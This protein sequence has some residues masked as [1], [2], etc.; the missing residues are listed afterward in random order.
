MESVFF[1]FPSDLALREKWTKEVKRTR[2][3]WSGPSEHSVLCEKHF[4][5]ECFEPA[6][7]IAATMGLHKRKRL[8]P[9]AV[10]TVFERR[11]QEPATAASLNEP[12]CSG[13]SRSRKR[14][15]ASVITPAAEKI[16]RKAYQKRERSRVSITPN[17]ALA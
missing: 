16:P 15:V 5:E 1:K 7:A 12:S 8:R 17:I 6:S 14:S 13:L 4:T 3:R 2:D 9:S 11:Q 10:P